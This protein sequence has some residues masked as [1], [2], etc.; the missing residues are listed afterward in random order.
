MTRLLTLAIPVALSVLALGCGGDDAASTEPETATATEPGGQTDDGA[1]SEGG[2]GEVFEVEEAGTVRLR[3][4][5]GRLEIVSVDPSSGWDY[6]ITEEE[7]D[8]VEID[9]TRGNEKIEFEAE[10]EDGR[11]ETR[12]ERD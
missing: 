12:V 11:I 1:G 4:D 7:R 9:F 8:E 5:G 10:L 3:A 2:G 6:R